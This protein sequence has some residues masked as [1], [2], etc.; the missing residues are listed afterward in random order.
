MWIN[1]RQIYFSQIT[2]ICI[3]LLSYFTEGETELLK[4]KYL[5]QEKTASHPRLLTQAV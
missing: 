5:T 4:F 2:Q 1:F 3:P